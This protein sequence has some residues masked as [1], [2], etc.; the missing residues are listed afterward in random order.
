MKPNPTH[1]KL[2]RWRGFN[3]L[4]KFTTRHNSP[5]QE[6]DFVW[7]AD[8]GFDFVRLPLS[9]RCWTSENDFRDLDES[10]VQEIDAAVEMGR[11]TN[12]HVNLNF[13]RAPG[14]CV[15]APAEA[16]NLWTDETALDAFAWQWSHFARR[17]KGIPSS[18]LSFNLLN[19][20]PFNLDEKDYVRVAARLIEAIRVEDPDRLILADGLAHGNVPVPGLAPLQV[21]QSTRGYVP[22]PISHYG[23]NWVE[24]DRLACE[25]LNWPLHLANGEVWD[26]ERL[27]R[28]QI[29]PWQELRRHGIGIHVGE[30][31]AFNKTPHEVALAWM[32]DCLELWKEAGWGWALWN[33][34]GEFGVLDSR[35]TDVRYESW[36]DHQLDRQMLEL[37]QA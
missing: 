3:L 29:E 28:E 26:K 35:R 1:S 23:A 36:N 8:W 16:L 7:I 5:Y 37:L 34:R 19:E 30:W 20:P 9:Y 31:G 33:F 25:T 14:Y 22:M 4:E 12:I 17:Y 24:P 2:P 18:Q 13:H 32:R 10:V 27:R 21:G 6:Q 11:R 15:N